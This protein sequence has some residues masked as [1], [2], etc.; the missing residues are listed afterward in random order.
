MTVPQESP[1]ER[2][3]V[4]PYPKNEVQEG[5]ILNFDELQPLK[6][7][8]S[9]DGAAAPVAGDAIPIAGG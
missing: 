2:F 6:L 9:N 5:E 4:P 3:P 7:K 8:P 1:R